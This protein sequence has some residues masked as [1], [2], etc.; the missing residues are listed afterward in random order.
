MPPNRKGANGIMF[1]GCPS[2]SHTPSHFFC[3][4]VFSFELYCINQSCSMNEKP[5]NIKLRLFYSRFNVLFFILNWSLTHKS[6]SDELIQSDELDPTRRRWV[7][8]AAP[9]LEGTPPPPIYVWPPG[10]LAFLKI[11]KGEVQS[12]ITIISKERVKISLQIGAKMMKI[13]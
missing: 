11:L 3:F 7:P 12:R 5:L 1:S 4:L 10:L 9:K 8:F 13:G 6:C 2:C